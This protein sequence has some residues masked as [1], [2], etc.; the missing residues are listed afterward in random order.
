PVYLDDSE[1]SDEWWRLMS[2]EFLQSRT[3][4]RSAFA[5]ILES[6]GA[7]TVA[8]PA[9]AEALLRV[10]NEA[11]LALA[12]RLGVRE[13]GDMELLDSDDQAALDYLAGM[14][15]LL[16]VALIGEELEFPSDD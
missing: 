8:S 10:L 7:G 2:E 3:A 15:Q 16:V 14:Q 1:A 6:A 11:R 12:A 4:D 13:E 5:M 9:E